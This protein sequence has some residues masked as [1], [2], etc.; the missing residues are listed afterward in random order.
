MGIEPFLILLAVAVYGLIHS[1]LA[2]LWAKARLR[3]WIGPPAERWYR[4]AY[5]LF[6]FVSLLPVLALPALLPDVRLY[7]I[8]SPWSYLTLAGQLLAVVALAVGVMQT[9]AWS[10]LGLQQAPGKPSQKSSQLV[11]HG[12]YRRV[13]HPLYTAGLVFIWLVPVMTRNLLALNIGL[14]IY[15][16]VGALFEERKLLREFGEVYIQ[17]RLDTPMLIPRLWRKTQASR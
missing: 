14:T 6:A 3:Q 16:V 10:F 13:R 2:S 9:G 17:Y 15:L 12:L 8:P 7:V 4:L 5:N 1:L 11:T